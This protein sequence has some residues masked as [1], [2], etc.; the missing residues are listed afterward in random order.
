MTDETARSL[1][2]PL[3]PRG[4]D[5]S[6][7]RRPRHARRRAGRDRPAHRPGRTEAG[8][9]ERAA[10]GA[11]KL[12]ALAPDARCRPNASSSRRSLVTADQ[13]RRADGGPG[14]R[15]GGQASGAGSLP[16]RCRA[17]TSES[18]R[19]VAA[20]ARPARPPS[21]VV[22]A[23]TRRCRRPCRGSVVGAQEDLRREIARAMHDG[24]A[25]SLTNIVLQAA[26][27]GAAGRTR[28]RPAPRRGASADVDGR[29]D[30]RCDQVVHLR[31][32]AD[33]PRRPR[34]RA[35]A[36]PRRPAS[37]GGEPASRSNSTRWARTGACRWTSRAACSGSSTRPW[38]PISRAR[39]DDV[40]VRARLGRGAGGARR[41]RPARRRRGRAARRRPDAD[42]PTA[43]RTCRRRWR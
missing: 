37:A 24:P 9:H 15:P 6:T 17:R 31:R 23:T 36:A 41:R 5:R 38:P 1:Q 32:P 21:C 39:P 2:R 18:V 35:D 3:D 30:P 19:G 26:D 42:E 40:Q 43:T 10:R 34:S 22:A 13:A 16:R 12:A 27:R 11:E 8:R 25:Q 33:G 20:T 7:R 14:R 29:A 28:S 4:A